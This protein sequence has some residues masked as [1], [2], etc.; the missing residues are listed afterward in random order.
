MA[1]LGGGAGAA[2]N[3]PL[4][5]PQPFYCEENAW[6]AARAALESGEPGPVEVVFVSSPGG[7]CAVWQ[8]RASEDPAAPI[9]WDYHVI[10]R[11]AGE[12]RD[13]DCRLGERL[14]ADAWLRASFPAGGRVP[15]RYRPWFR[16]VPARVFLEQFA[17]DRRHM[18]DADGGYR[19]APPPWPPIVA[20]S[21]VRHTL[22]AFL[23]FAP[24]ALP[25][26]LDLPA[27]AA[28]LPRL[29]DP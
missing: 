12:I 2:M 28:S 11:V 23:D 13:P 20:P 14:P 4:P 8:Q 19:A 26:W 9:L 24:S 1:G 18:R 10:V 29:P 7:A 17:S 5:P 3:R 6:H 15:A 21:G 22:P 27:F 16:V 25:P